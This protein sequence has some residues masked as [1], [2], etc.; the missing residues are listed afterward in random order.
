MEGRI[1]EARQRRTKA[2]TEKKTTRKR[3]QESRR[4]NRRK[5]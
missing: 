4:L 2:P 5:K 3:T 1:V